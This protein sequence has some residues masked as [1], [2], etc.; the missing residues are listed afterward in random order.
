MILVSVVVTLNVQ[1]LSV[2]EETATHTPLEEFKQFVAAPP[3]IEE[4]LYRTLTTGS[5][6]TGL[7]RGEGIRGLKDA[8]LY[9]HARWQ[10]DCLFLK[11]GTN[12]DVSSSTRQTL[13]EVN[14]RFQNEYWRLD[15]AGFLTSWVDGSKTPGESSLQPSRCFHT[16]THQFKEMMNMGIM[17]IEVGAVKWRGNSLSAE[18]YVPEFKTPVRV[19]GKVIP[20]MNGYAKEMRVTYRSRMGIYN[21]ILRYA[22][23]EN[24]G[25]PF[26]PSIIQSFFL[27]PDGEV[28]LMECQIFSIK[29]A[30]EPLPR[31]S[32]DLEPLLVSR[33]MPR[34]LFTNGNWYAQNLVGGWAPIRKPSG[35]LAG[36]TAVPAKFNG[37]GLYYGTVAVTT[38]IALTAILKTK[39]NKTNA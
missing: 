21:Y 27:S 2:G 38:L 29:T 31:G 5:A 33:E 18:G 39:P 13:E 4:A 37:N 34:I 35:E 3:I 15:R 25:M 28:K 30:S 17:Q 14:A 16:S 19:E 36:F 20:D 22:Y 7:P 9:F 24:V 8:M 32:F 10:S 11:V 1:L 23:H 12:T 26:L 6:L